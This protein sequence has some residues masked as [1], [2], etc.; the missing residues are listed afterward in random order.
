M[1]VPDATVLG[2]IGAIAAFSAAMT[3]K[4]ADSYFQDV[5]MMKTQLSDLC[6]RSEEFQADMRIN[7]DR[8]CSLLDE[9]TKTLYKLN[10]KSN[11]GKEVSLG[12]RTD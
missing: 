4:I 2:A 7:S 5:K 8:M 11:K 12:E 10:G 1:T 6:A 9:M 3:K